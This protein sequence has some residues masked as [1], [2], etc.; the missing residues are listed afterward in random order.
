[1]KA[2]IEG[3]GKEESEN[4]EGKMDLECK[5]RRVWIDCKRQRMMAKLRGGTVELGIETGRWQ[6]LRRKDRVCKECSSG[7]VEDVGH[8]VLTIICKP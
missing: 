3:H 6:G 8:F 1:M 4:R 2:V 5:A 7:E